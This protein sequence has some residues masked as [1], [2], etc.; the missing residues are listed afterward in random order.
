VRKMSSL[1]ERPEFRDI[2]SN[3]AYPTNDIV[4]DDEALDDWIRRDVTTGHHISGSNKM[5]VDSDPMAVV[6]QLGKVRGVE[7]LRV[8]DASI[9]PTCVRANINATVIAMAE[10]MAELI[11]Q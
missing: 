5:G 2:V 7:G 4:G 11:T 3:P 9:M 6:G 10:R 1:V 8:V